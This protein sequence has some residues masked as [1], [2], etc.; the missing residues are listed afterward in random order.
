M[1]SFIAA[2]HRNER[3]GRRVSA[4]EAIVQLLELA[5]DFG[6]AKRV[7]VAKWTATE[8][9][10]PK[11]ENSADKDARPVLSLSKAASSRSSKAA[12]SSCFLLISSLRVCDWSSNC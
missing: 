11:P 12:S 6:C 5:Y 10:E 3:L 1:E 8:R 9:R 2:R 4:G 7:H